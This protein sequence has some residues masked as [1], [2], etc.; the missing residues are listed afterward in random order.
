M[1]FDSNAILELVDLGFDAL[2]QLPRCFP[3]LVILGHFGHCRLKAIIY[4]IEITVTIEGYTSAYKGKGQPGYRKAP[5]P[6][7]AI[8]CVLHRSANRLSSIIA[9]ESSS[10]LT[11]TV[12]FL[13]ISSKWLNRAVLRSLAIA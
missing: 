8:N 6:E 11:I 1:L 5:I 2:L 3:H 12:D 10:C 13:G 7:N 9:D 4:L